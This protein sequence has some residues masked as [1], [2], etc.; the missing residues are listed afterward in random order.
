MNEGTSNG[1]DKGDDLKGKKA[2]QN[3]EDSKMRRQG[4][5]MVRLT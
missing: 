2:M 5:L 3:N 1:R 4:W